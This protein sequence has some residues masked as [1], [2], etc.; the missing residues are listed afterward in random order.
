MGFFFMNYLFMLFFLAMSS[1]PDTITPKNLEWKNRLLII[2]HP[3]D[4]GFWQQVQMES[5]LEDR[6]LLIFW[7]DR[8]ELLNSNFD[9]QL[10]QNAFLSRIPAGSDW[11]LIG[12]DGGAKS[13]GKRGPDI[14]L[15]FKTIDA[16]P[17]R[18]RERKG[19]F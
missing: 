12:L 14:D 13:S 16:M 18:I 1:Q 3:M 5:K 19:I 11:V 4:E 8:G 9:G 7:F 10:D 15:I 17:M 6:K 2:N